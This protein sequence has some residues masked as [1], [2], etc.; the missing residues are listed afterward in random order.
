MHID[1]PGIFF[2]FFFPS[3][4]LSLTTTR[5]KIS[6]FR[7]TGILLR[8]FFQFIGKISHIRLLLLLYY[9]A[10]FHF[11][12]LCV[13]LKILIELLPCCTCKVP[14]SAY[15]PLLFHFST[16][17]PFYS[18]PASRP[19]RIPSTFCNLCIRSV[20]HVPFCVMFTNFDLS[21]MVLLYR[22][23]EIDIFASVYSFECYSFVSVKSLN[24][25]HS[26]STCELQLLQPNGSNWLYIILSKTITTT[27]IMKMSI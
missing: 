19:F 13:F 16:V 10:F 7:S 9:K 14:V 8:L 6:R 26:L 1:L 24:A 15:V 17:V 12:C 23:L 22:S 11:I 18:S 25:Q 3:S 5:T 2:C 4:Y 21:A 27:A 20:F